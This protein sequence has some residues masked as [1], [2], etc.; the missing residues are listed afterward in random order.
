[1]PS[2]L[3]GILAFLGGMVFGGAINW[4]TLVL[5]GSLIPPPEG[6]DV[7]DP[8]SI[9]ALADQLKFKHFIFPFL[10]HALGTLAGA[11]LAALLKPDSAL[12]MGILVGIGF[13][14]GGIAAAFMIPAP[15]AFIALDLIMAYLP[16]GW[17]GAKLSEKIPLQDSGKWVS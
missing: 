12:L 7:Q 15:T 3:Q 11:T 16:M 8:A 10:A 6:M 14:L 17:L 2:I 4:G 9:A 13:L 5:G 1:M